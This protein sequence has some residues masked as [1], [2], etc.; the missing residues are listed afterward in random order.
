MTKAADSYPE[1][2]ELKEDLASLKTHVS[3]LT[4]S[5]KRDGVEG[6]D[7]LS[8]SCERETRSEHCDCV[9]RRLSREYV[10]SQSELA[11]ESLISNSAASYLG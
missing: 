5:L 8:A 10:A 9:C 2:N 7:K 6:A 4:S 11:C 3:E 1:I